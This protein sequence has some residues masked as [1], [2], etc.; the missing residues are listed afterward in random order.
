[1]RSAAEPVTFFS[2]V[3]LP[4]SGR[5]V[6]TVD[7]LRLGMKHAARRRGCKP[8]GIV[9]GHRHEPSLSSSFARSKL[10]N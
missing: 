9:Q 6:R 3:L 1:M 4:Y 8:A 5:T 10:K 2:L 7:T